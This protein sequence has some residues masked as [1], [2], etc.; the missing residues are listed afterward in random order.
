[1][2]RAGLCREG[3]RY[4]GLEVG[5]HQHVEGIEAGEDHARN[6]GPGEE[7][8]DGH[9]GHLAGNDD[10]DQAGG[11]QLSQGSRGCN[12]TGGQ[13]MVVS[14]FE[15][16][17]ERNQPH[18]DHGGG[19]DSRGSG[20][21]GSDND[22][23]QGETTS[24]RTHQKADRG[25]EALGQTRLL[26]NGPHEDKKRYGDKDEVGNAVG[27]P[28]VEEKVEIG[29]GKDAQGDADR[30]ENYGGAGER[31]GNGIPGQEQDQEDAEH[32]QRQPLE[33]HW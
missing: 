16:R 23:C 25:Q 26:E 33:G 29:Q 15:H 4:L 20:E 9:V 21:Q 2:K 1:M 3:G 27:E 7:I 8:A 17:R 31:E 6:Q 10:Q 24:N 19:H 12:H 13:A 28:A 30:R 14:V 22:H 11:D 18:H 5:D 32:D